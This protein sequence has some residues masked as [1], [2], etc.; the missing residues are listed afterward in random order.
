VD[1]LNLYLIYLI[2]MVMIFDLI[3]SHVY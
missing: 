1:E 2:I 3:M